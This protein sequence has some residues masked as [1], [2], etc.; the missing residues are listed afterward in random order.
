VSFFDVLHFSPRYLINQGQVMDTQK[1]S[2]SELIYFIFDWVYLLFSLFTFLYFI[3]SIVDLTHESDLLLAYE[4]IFLLS[5]FN[6]LI[7]SAIILI[8]LIFRLLGIAKK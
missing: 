7:F 1:T 2:N 3:S 6:V 4:N 8:P 5:I